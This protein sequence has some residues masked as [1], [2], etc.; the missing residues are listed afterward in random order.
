VNGFTRY[1]RGV[2][3]QKQM[4]QG[5]AESPVIPPAFFEFAGRDEQIE[6]KIQMTTNVGQAAKVNGKRNCSGPSDV[7]KMADALEAGQWETLLAGEEGR[8]FTTDESR[9]DG[10]GEEVGAV[11]EVA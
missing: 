6:R 5:R 8:I 10:R 7:R 11:A 2:L 9:G 1:E 3:S 4:I